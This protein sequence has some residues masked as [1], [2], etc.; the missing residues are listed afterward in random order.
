MWSR[1]EHSSKRSR[2]RSEHDFVFA[3]LD[4]R[5]FVCAHSQVS[6]LQEFQSHEEFLDEV[7]GHLIGLSASGA[8]VVLTPITVGGFLQW[9]E[10]YGTAR[11]LSNLHVF[12]ADVLAFR[13]QVRVRPVLGDRPSKLPASEGVVEFRR[14]LYDAWRASVSAPDRPDVLKSYARLVVEGWCRPPGYLA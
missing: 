8:S 6:G 13:R 4:R 2:T 5:E 9:S 1:L 14:S 7:E 3:T 12:A 10:N 11:D